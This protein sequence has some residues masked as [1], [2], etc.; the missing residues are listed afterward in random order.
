MKWLS[1]LDLN[2]GELQNARIQNLATTPSNPVQGQ[3]YYNSVD[4]TFYGWNGTIWI[5]L[6]Q[7]L[8]GDAIINLINDSSQKI[9]DDN[10]SSNVNSAISKKHSHSNKT[11]LDSTTASFTTELKTK[12]DGI[13]TDANKVETS[14]NNGYI[15]IDGVEKTVYIHP[16]SGT[17][18]HGT[19]KS[20][21]GLG[22]VE[23]KSSETIRSEITATNVTNALGYTPVKSGG[24]PE[25]RKGLESQKP[26]P[27]GSGLLYV[28]TDVK[29][30]WFDNGDEWIML[31]GGD[32][33]L[34]D[35]IYF[36]IR[37]ERFTVTEEGQDVFYL[38]K[39]TYTPNTNTIFI[40]IFGAKQGNDAIEE[41]SPVSFKVKQPLPVGTK[42]LVEYYEILN[43]EPFPYHASEHI[44]DGVDQIPNATT[45]SNGLMSKE[46][47]TKLNGIASGAE[48]NQNAFSNIKVGSSTIVADSKTDTLEITS[49]TGISL[50]ADTTNDKV[51]MSVSSAPKLTTARTISLTNDVSGSTSF[52]G[53]DNASISVTLANSGVTA[54]TYPK[55]TVD[56]KGRVTSGDALSVSDIPS[57]PVNKISNFHTQVRTSRLDQMTPPAND[58]SMNGNKITAL[59]DPVDSQD[60]ATKFYVDTIK[61]GLDVKDSVR[62]ATTT[63]LN[64]TYSSGILTASSHGAISI[65]GVSLSLNDRVLVKNQST[66]S[67]NGIY[68]VSQVGSGSTPWKLTRTNDANMSDKVTAGLYVWV[69]EGNTNADSGWILTTNDPITLGTTALT[70][71][72]F[73]GAGMITVGTGLQKN[74]NTIS[75]TNTGVSY[76]TYTKVTVDA[77]GRVTSGANIASSDVTGALGYTPCRKY[78]ANIG[79]GSATEFTVTHNLNTKDIAVGIEEVATSEMVFTD[80]IKTSVNAIKILF[81]QVPTS[82]QYRVTIVG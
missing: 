27:S 6:G 80:I 5:D 17:N 29:K 26:D 65:D 51:T 73:S 32:G 9:D 57:L 40:Y 62:V 54:G 36:I 35:D 38:T 25:V 71:T 81:A 3:I 8:T 60:A 20:D 33:D 50:S 34:P 49:G 37:Q 1:N 56:S 2:K 79:N 44:D 30:I 69:T 41:L 78:S 66:A 21:I 18:P 77:Q 61:Q 14:I 72:Q 23:N 39:G 42:I 13:S 11:I 4:K 52:D 53:S 47:K 24:V 67:Q 28:S 64:A 12:L 59:A 22:N 10:L 16:G 76:G 68:Y 55:V 46:D 48:V 63:N 74:G 19:T 75:L 43:G 58:L 82:N 7:V 31:G 70:F 45:S 15:K